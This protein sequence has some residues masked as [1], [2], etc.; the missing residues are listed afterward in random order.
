[1]DS[2]WAEQCGHVGS[3]RTSSRRAASWPLEST[4]ASARNEACCV[5]NSSRRSRPT[6]ARSRPREPPLDWPATQPLCPDESHARHTA[7]QRGHEVWGLGLAVEELT[8]S[9]GGSAR[10]SSHMNRMISRRRDTR[11]CRIRDRDPR[12]TNKEPEGIRR[13]SHRA[14]RTFDADLWRELCRQEHGHPELAAAE[15]NDR[16]QRSRA[17]SLGGA[18]FVS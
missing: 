10:S 7:S 3:A 14:S 13:D 17:A 1:M 12:A 16:E 4:S 6:L 9:A 2:R 5:S 11:E 15:A 8:A 18:R